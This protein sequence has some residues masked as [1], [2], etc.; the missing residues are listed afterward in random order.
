MVD[1]TFAPCNPYSDKPHVLHLV[2]Y[3][4]FKQDHYICFT[5]TYY[6]DGVVV[7]GI[8][9]VHKTK[10]P[11]PPSKIPM[12]REQIEHVLDSEM[13]TSGDIDIVPQFGKEHHGVLVKRVKDGVVDAEILIDAQHFKRLQYIICKAL[14]DI[15]LMAP[16]MNPGTEYITVT[17]KCVQR[18][19][20]MAY[21][22]QR[23][24]EF[25]LYVF[26][27]ENNYDDYSR[28]LVNGVQLKD[29][30][31]F[32]ERAKLVIQC[33]GPLHAIFDDPASASYAVATKELPYSADYFR[34][35]S[36]CICNNPKCRKILTESTSDTSDTSI[37]NNVVKQ[38]HPHPVCSETGETNRHLQTPIGVLDVTISSDDTW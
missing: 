9:H 32:L 35:M 26:K 16:Y 33:E 36:L 3:L 11:S 18:N 8:D 4:Y 30:N 28:K 27:K 29:V 7:F 38:T 2:E 34:F 17:D 19:L 6:G 37:G 21:L 22:R 12:T 1:A 14:E 20:T 31:K 23:Y 15:D 10:E 25:T 24:E 13:G 5:I